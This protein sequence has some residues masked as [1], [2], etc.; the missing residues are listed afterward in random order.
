MLRLLQAANVEHLQNIME[1]LSGYKPDLSLILLL[2]PKTFTI[3]S[4]NEIEHMT[5]NQ[6]IIK[7]H[8]PNIIISLPSISYIP[9]VLTETCP[10]DGP[11][12]KSAS[13]CIVVPSWVNGGS[14]ICTLI[15]LFFSKIDSPSSVIEVDPDFS[16]HGIISEF[17]L[18]RILRIKQRIR[19]K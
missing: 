7:T 10:E 14:P 1:W 3:I 11:P 19:K 13:N 5:I 12:I 8:L 9:V 2:L 6:K 17:Q 15:L 18:R 16:V 4:D